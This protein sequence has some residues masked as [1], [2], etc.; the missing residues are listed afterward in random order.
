MRPTGGARLKDILDVKTEER[1]IRLLPGRLRPR[2]ESKS[3]VRPGHGPR[4][5]FWA[6][7][8]LESIESWFPG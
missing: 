4:V 8:C 1:G 6:K 3:P 7:S 2:P 5:E